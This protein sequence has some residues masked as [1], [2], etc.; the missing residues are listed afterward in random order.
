MP[1]ITPI[2]FLQTLKPA[3][4]SDDPGDAQDRFAEF[5]SQHAEDEDDAVAVS[6][7][8]LIDQLDNVRRKIAF[9]AVVAVVLNTPRATVMHSV[10]L[11]K[12]D[13]L[14]ERIAKEDVFKALDWAALP[15]LYSDRFSSLHAA[16]LKKWQELLDRAAAS[17]FSRALGL[18][19]GM[20][21]SDPTRPFAMVARSAADLLE[22][23]KPGKGAPQP[24]SL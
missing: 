4:L 20:E 9:D 1:D 2:E 21:D 10:G 8:N 14:I 18:A 12:W 3:L 17:D 23:R 6:V 7:M 5:V 11:E 16:G 24:P 13:T 15:C 19:R 22:S